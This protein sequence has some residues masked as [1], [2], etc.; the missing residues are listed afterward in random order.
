SNIFW[1]FSVGFKVLAVIIAIIGLFQFRAYLRVRSLTYLVSSIYLLIFTVFLLLAPISNSGLNKM[2]FTPLNKFL[3]VLMMIFL[4]WLVYLSVTR[5]VKWKGREIFELAA[6]SI[7]DAKNGFTERP[8]PTGKINFSKSDLIEFAT[9]LR[10][11]QIA[12]PFFE[13]NKI[14][15]VP[16]KMG[17]EFYYLYYNNIEYRDKTW[18]MFD[19]SGDVS[20]HISK[21]DYLD[22]KES[23]SFDQLCDSMGDLFK[24]FFDL[25][26]KGEE[27]RI[28]D[29]L[30]SLNISIF[31]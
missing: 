26:V 4:V 25:F 14:A 31:K 3:G 28:I 12:L 18:I 20:V 17:Q 15:L 9:F 2:A 11:N 8:F 5:K 13:D 21:K 30:D 29:R 6:M 16:I 22:Y 23:L 24:E 1:G 10:V 7:K 27:V 19:Y